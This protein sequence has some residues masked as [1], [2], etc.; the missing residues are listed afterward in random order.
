MAKMFFNDELEAKKIS[1]YA[2]NVISVQVPI[3][4]ISYYDIRC[5]SDEKEITLS[6]LFGRL[7]FQVNYE[8]EQKSFNI[9]T[10][11]SS[12]TFIHPALCD[13]NIVDYVNF[14]DSES[15]KLFKILFDNKEKLFH[16]LLDV[17][18]SYG[19]I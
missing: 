5:F 15:N 10:D 17:Y 11:R 7:F 6:F 2:R 3:P 9:K 16:L 19:L 4:N 12:F 14:L 18:K 13:V 8:R 1:D